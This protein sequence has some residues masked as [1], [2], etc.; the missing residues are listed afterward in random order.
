LLQRLLIYRLYPIEVRGYLNDL[1]FDARKNDPDNFGSKP[2][3]FAV[4]N[5]RYIHGEE[6][7]DRY[8]VTKL[9]EEMPTSI[10]ELILTLFRAVHHPDKQGYHTFHKVQ[11]FVLEGMQ[12]RFTAKGPL[13]EI[14]PAFKVSNPPEFWYATV[15]PIRISDTDDIFSIDKPFKYTADDQTVLLKYFRTVDRIIMENE[16]IQSPYIIKFKFDLDVFAKYGIQQNRD[17][18]NDGG[19]KPGDPSYEFLIND[20]RFSQDGYIFLEATLLSPPK[21]PPR[22]PVHER[23]NKPEWDPRFANH[24][25]LDNILPAVKSSDHLKAIYGLTKGS[26]TRK[27]GGGGSLSYSSSYIVGSVISLM[28]VIVSSVVGSIS[29]AA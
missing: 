22:T 24:G 11:E 28:V 7:S 17:P 14:L 1:L 9:V 6:L 29:N 4:E 5:T 10:K 13:S 27:Y 25:S 2:I 8:E 15:P 18:R 3:V 23:V 16:D 19:K 21:E 26:D 12:G 20:V